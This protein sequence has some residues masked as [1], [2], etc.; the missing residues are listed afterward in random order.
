M[1]NIMARSEGFILPLTLILLL[2]M[3]LVLATLYQAEESHLAVYYAAKQNAITTQTLPDLEKQALATAQNA[4]P[5]IRPNPSDSPQ[6]KVAYLRAIDPQ[7][8][9]LIWQERLDP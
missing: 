9:N 5:P 1:E 6:Q 2:V 8:E 4:L 7:T 3:S